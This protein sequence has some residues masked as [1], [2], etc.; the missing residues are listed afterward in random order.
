VSS[1]QSV[2]E[3][4]RLE[5][6][7][8]LGSER[9]TRLNLAWIQLE[10]GPADAGLSAELLRELHTL[11]GEAGLLGFS[12][13]TNICHCLEDLLRTVFAS[14]PIDPAAGDL[15]LR[16]FDLIAAA[17]E[18]ED[19][20]GA[21][22]VG[23]QAFLDA[24]LP[25]GGA[26]TSSGG[27][28]APGLAPGP[29]ASAPLSPAPISAPIPAPIPAQTAVQNPA[30]Q[31]PSRSVPSAGETSLR[32]TA[33]RLDHMRELVGELMLTR[34]RLELSAREFRRARQTAREYQEEISTKSEEAGLMF[35]KLLQAIGG[36]ELRLRDDRHR[37]SNLISELDGVVRE[38]RMVPLSTLLRTYPVAVHSLARELGREVRLEFDGDAVEVDRAVLDRL[39]DPLLHLIRNA[40]DH[41]IEP[42]EQRVRAGKRKEGRILLRARLHGQQLD[43]EII[44]D[45]AGISVEVVRARAVEL[46]F[47]DAASAPALSDEQVLR[48]LFQSGMSTRREVTKISGRGIGLDVVLRSAEE[49]GGSVTVRTIAGQ[50]T[51]FHLSVPL[52]SALAT[53]VLFSVKTGRYALPAASVVE[54]LDASAYPCIQGI[55]GPAI[56]Y[57]ERFVPLISLETLL[58]ETSSTSEG[59]EP[60]H[61]T[62]E[63][64]M[65]VRG[66]R[67][68]VA[69]SGSARHIQRE[70]VQKTV[71]KGFAYSRLIT[72]AIPME[73]GTLS[74][75]LSPGELLP[76]GGAKP[77]RAG[78]LGEPAAA[79]RP[80]RTVL[81]VDDSP[82][83]RDLLTE[84]L[85]A[86]GARVI[87]AG[88]GE[89]ALLR[90]QASPEIALLVTDIDMP[91]LD[92][93]GLVQRVRLRAGRRLPV[94]IISMRASTEE[95]GRAIAAGADAYMVKTDLTHAGLWTLLARFLG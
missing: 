3:R 6:F 82:V 20:S 13:L 37:V 68:L 22:L 23:L 17:L 44:D 49:L 29:Q 72:A 81:V 27:D 83:V 57:G 94:V 59:A 5:M 60:E 71:G 16:G 84:S 24:A 32:V 51:A 53:M 7:R 35:G 33:A 25:L 28:P 54:L 38:L 52:S 64:L 74:L 86:H 88:D 4:R 76:D 66:R 2:A 48:T 50:E 21:D 70:V 40:V 62:S 30:P 14:G 34:A 18:S 93:I 31:A 91:K 46:G 67:G 55:D 73:D 87:E 85:R 11:K 79:S 36:I 9:L 63:R 43:V 15:I 58:D 65:L 77:M 75:V 90:L 61:P 95:Q 47:C 89:E 56:R 92:G 42:P 69:L 45:G 8:T 26:P 39:A 10:Q 19:A 41:G 12:A 78:P 80:E 1:P